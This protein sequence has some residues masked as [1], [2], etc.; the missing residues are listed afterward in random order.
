MVARRLARPVA[1]ALALAVA[2]VVPACGDNRGPAAGPDA[3]PA[4]DSAA[5]VT[6]A[7]DV[8]PILQ[9]ACASCHDAAHDDSAGDYPFPASYAELQRPSRMCQGDTVG[10][11][12]GLAVAN[13]DVEGNGCRTYVVRPFH[14]EGWPCLTAPQQATIAAWVAAGMPAE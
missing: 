9:A 14:R 5:P 13:Q 3:A 1:F 7:R 4:I 11:C 6:F 10:T 2:A 8:Q 12:V